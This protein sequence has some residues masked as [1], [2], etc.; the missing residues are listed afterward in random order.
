[1]KL[2]I[3]TALAL[4]L[5]TSLAS[6]AGVFA[7]TTNINSVTSPTTN[8]LNSVFIMNNITADNNDIAK[9]NAWAVGDS[10]TIVFWNGNT[11]ATQTSPTTMPLYSVFLLNSTFG[12]A[13]GGSSSSGVILRYN[14][15]SWSQ[16]NNITFTGTANKTD[17]VNA[18]LYSVTTNDNG[19]IGWIVGGGGMALSWNNTGWWYGM[20]TTTTNTL[21][22]VS[23]IH[24]ATQA[25]A[26]GD[27]GTIITND[28]TWSNMTSP[29]TANLNALQI[30]NATSG[31]AAGGTDVNNGTFLTLSGT[32]WNVSNK[33][34]QGTTTNTSS[35]VNA[36]IYSISVNNQTSAW[37]V[38][39][40]GLV[41]YYNGTHWS[42]E[43]NVVSGSLR[44]VSMVHGTSN[45]SVQAWAVGDGGKILA[46]NGTNWVP[47]L[48]IMV[49]PL[50][51]SIGLVIALIGKVKIA[52]KKLF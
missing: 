20:N 16:F 13:V 24:N 41:S 7:Q 26:V 25:W 4:C 38:G 12:W 34:I 2:S 15:T 9:L 22:S 47:E 46:F 51:M 11:W 40:N 17:T 37:A 43:A 32:T 44:G 21:R 29:T 49:I 23:M 31:I 18:T 6:V 3:K 19:T 27:K 42:C 30:I 35:T 14:G 1:M 48:P 45:G 10:G 28:G 39:S 8:T 5:I 50:L 52:R 33:V 36:T